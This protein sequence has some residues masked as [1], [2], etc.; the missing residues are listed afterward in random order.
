MVRMLKVV[1][2]WDDGVHDDIPLIEILRKYGARASFNLNPGLNKDKREGWYNQ[3]LQK[4]VL[5][6]ARSEL[7]A[8]YEGFTIANHTVS[9]PRPLEI[10]LEQWRQEVVD[11][12]K[13]LQDFFQQP[14]LG[15]AYPFGDF[16]DA[17]AAVL[18]EAGHVYGRTTKKATPCLPVENAMIFHSDCHFLDEHFWERYAQ[19]KQSPAQ[20]F[21]FWGHS[22]ELH[23]PQRWTDFEACIQKIATDPES[24]WAELPEL[25]TA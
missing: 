15:F 2:C 8:V 1:Q 14:V 22:Y 17:T 21:Y 9:H 3:N 25:F 12:R 18:R 20:V 19:A 7:R 11:G 23:K 13:R 16:N 24:E 6:L 4:E 10:P 5:R